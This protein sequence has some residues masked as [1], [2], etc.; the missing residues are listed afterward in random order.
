MVSILGPH[1]RDRGSI[2]LVEIR[3]STMVSIFGFHPEDRGSIPRVGT[4]SLVLTVSMSGCD[5]GGASSSLAVGSKLI[6]RMIL[7]Y[8]QIIFELIMAGVRFPWTAAVAWRL[9][10][11]KSK[12]D[13]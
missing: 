7:D 5:P 13:Y 2:P 10:S 3:H 8:P 1:P 9:K 4:S 12:I 6:V 11:P